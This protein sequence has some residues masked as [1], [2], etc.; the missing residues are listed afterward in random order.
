MLLPVSAL[1]MSMTRPS[2][3]LLLVLELLPVGWVSRHALGEAGHRDAL[4]DRDLSRGWDQERADH[5]SDEPSSIPQP[6]RCR[7]PGRATRTGRRRGT[8]GR[9]LRDEH[10]GQPHQRPQVPP[11]GAL[12]V[13]LTAGLAVTVSSPTG[14]LTGIVPGPLT[15]CGLATSLA[16]S[17]APRTTTRI[18]TTN[19]VAVLPRGDKQQED[20]D[21]RL[22]QR[23]AQPV[24]HSSRGRHPAT[25]RRRR[26]GGC[27]ARAHHRR[28]AQQAPGPWR[29]R[30]PCGGSAFSA[31]TPGQQ[32]LDRR[33]D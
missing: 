6:R 23:V 28:G 8:P 1:P 16:T 10:R 26:E 11:C 33:G 17:V 29:R 13:R 5:G 21:S 15:D 18:P 32:R 27:A 7:R 30:A 24:G 20:Q 3:V 12:A 22:Q 4:E 14:I 19:R 25:P 2:H 31:A 9:V